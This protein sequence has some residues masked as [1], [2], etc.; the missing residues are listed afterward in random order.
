MP[1][2]EPRLEWDV[3]GCAVFIPGS[4]GTY[5]EALAIAEKVARAEGVTSWSRLSGPY[6]SQSR[7]GL[8]VS[9]IPKI[10]YPCCERELSAPRCSAH[11]ELAVGRYVEKKER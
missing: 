11:G 1:S 10:D 3:S 6:Y 2:E 5:S 4:V 8:F 9:I 7:Y